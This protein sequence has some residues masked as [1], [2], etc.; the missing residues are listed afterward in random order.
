GVC[1]APWWLFHTLG[2][3]VRAHVP[4]A[5]ARVPVAPVSF[6][7]PVPAGRVRALLLPLASALDPYRHHPLCSRPAPAVSLPWPRLARR[8]ARHEVTTVSAPLLTG[9]QWEPPF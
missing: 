7:V 6:P 2:Q 5:P 1:P 3:R 8:F 9:E 4:D